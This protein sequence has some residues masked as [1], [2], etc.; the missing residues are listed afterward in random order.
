MTMPGTSHMQT[1]G[2][3]TSQS[4]KIHTNSISLSLFSTTVADVIDI[5]HTISGN[6]KPLKSNRC[7]ESRHHPLGQSLLRSLNVFDAAINIFF[8]VLFW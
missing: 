7:N 4:A 8:P 6:L 5:E 2:V 1:N 3:A